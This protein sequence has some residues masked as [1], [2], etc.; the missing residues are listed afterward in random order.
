[1]FQCVW[2]LYQFSKEAREELENKISEI[3]RNS[4]KKVYFILDEWDI[5]KN[6]NYNFLILREYKENGEFSLLAKVKADH[7]GA[8]VTQV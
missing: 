7:H 2:V 1:M 8:W 6:K 3:A 5:V 4:Q